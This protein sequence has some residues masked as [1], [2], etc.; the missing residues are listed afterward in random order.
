[1]F[2]TI[3]RVVKDRRARQVENNRAKAVEAIWE[4]R[5]RGDTRSIHLATTEAQRLTNIAL[6]L[7]A[8]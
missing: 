2:R 5:K 3:S 6:K 7:E 8:R 1:M 4:A